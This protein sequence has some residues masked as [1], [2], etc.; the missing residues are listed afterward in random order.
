VASWIGVTSRG[1]G[2]FFQRHL[3]AVKVGLALFFAAL[4]ALTLA[5]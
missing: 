1:L 5:T 3:V 4:A 2:V